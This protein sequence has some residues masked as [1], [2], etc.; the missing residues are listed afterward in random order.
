[1]LQKPIKL[2][3]TRQLRLQQSPVTTTLKQPLRCEVLSIDG[4]PLVLC[5]R[6][7]FLV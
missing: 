6:A 5:I 2:G 3:R 4:R 7:P 1:M